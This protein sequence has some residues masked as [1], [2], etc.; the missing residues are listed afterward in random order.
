M[1][2][3]FFFISSSWHSVDEHSPSP[4]F[5]FVFVSMFSFLFRFNRFVFVSMFS[6]FF[7]FSAGHHISLRND[8]LADI[9]CSV[10]NWFLF[11]LRVE[12]VFWKC[13][14]ECQGEMREREREREVM[15]ESERERACEIEGVRERVR[16]YAECLFAKCSTFFN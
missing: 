15:W 6:V 8:I 2:T 5:R 11:V 12:I 10:L 16:K 4:L 14:R 9:C 7:S 1:F 3:T 13:E